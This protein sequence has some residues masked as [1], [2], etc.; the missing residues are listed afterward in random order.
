VA[1]VD[2]EEEE[3]EEK[4]SRGRI[5]R[6]RELTRVEQPSLPYCVE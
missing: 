1:E 6:R 3:R 4:R 2:W 5:G